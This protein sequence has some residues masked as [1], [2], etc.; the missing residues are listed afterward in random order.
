M[1]KPIFVAKVN[2]NLSKLEFDNIKQILARDLKD[3]YH[4]L[5]IGVTETESIEFECF[6]ADNLKPIDIEELQLKIKL[7]QKK[8]K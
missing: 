3:D 7:W 5:V 6:N 1:I 4:I 2:C 8:D